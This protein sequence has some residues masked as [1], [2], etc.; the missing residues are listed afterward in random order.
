MTA[1]TPEQFRL[2]E[3]ELHNLAAR[4]LSALDVPDG[5]AATVAT[6]LV[7]ADI[8]GHHSHGVQL[9]PL[10]AA[11]V[12]AGGIDVHATAE[13]VQALPGIVHIEAHGGFGQVAMMLAARQAAQTAKTSGLSCVTVAGNNH[14]G[15]LAAYRRPFVD[16]DVTAL[17]L[18]ISGASVA[19]P[20]GERATQG[21]NALCLVTGRS[22]GGTPLVVD[23]ATGIVACG[24]IRA[25]EAAGRPV[26]AGWLLDA[27]GS[28]TTDASEL[29]R[30]GAVPVFG[31]HKGLG[32]SLIVEV[33]AGILSGGTIS[34]HVN[35]Q[36][37]HPDRVMGSSQMIVAFGNAAFTAPLDRVRLLD[38]LE[39]SVRAAYPSGPPETWYPEQKET[40]ATKAASTSGISLPGALVAELLR[41]TAVI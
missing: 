26:P 13:I 28:P 6:V 36:R 31:G 35:R 10:Y 38:C 24:K 40:R 25:A 22:E 27:A 30:G 32:V 29:D 11:R 39:D 7:D 8:R 9:L 34:A 14:V 21:N 2:T 41:S 33:L 12:R 15:M 3:P 23:M 16:A 37:R 17:I 5:T 1:T 4:Y 19:P 18:N 20:L